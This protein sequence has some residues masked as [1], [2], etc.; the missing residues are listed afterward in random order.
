MRMHPCGRAV[1]VAAF[2]V[3]SLAALAD[4]QFVG[5]YTGDHIQAV[6][7]PAG[8]SAYPFTGGV[9]DRAGLW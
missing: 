9:Q 2:T 1:V 6:V 8:E 7:R 5:T 4:P 3:A